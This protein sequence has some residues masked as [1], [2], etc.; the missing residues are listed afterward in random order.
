MITTQIN[1]QIF[2]RDTLGYLWK[3]YHKRF[4]SIELRFRPKVQV[5]WDRW[6]WHGV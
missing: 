6:H 1:R 2:C 4:C 5:L 3:P